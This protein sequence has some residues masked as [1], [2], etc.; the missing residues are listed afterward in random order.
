M[1]DRLEATLKRNN[2]ISVELSKPEIIQDI[3]I[4]YYQ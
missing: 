1:I 4:L 2:D 3:K